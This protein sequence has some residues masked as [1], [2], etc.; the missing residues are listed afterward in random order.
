MSDDIS[1]PGALSEGS[2]RWLAFL[3]T[4]ALIVLMLL[5]AEGAVRIRQ[6][7]KYGSAAG[8]EDYWTIDPKSGMRVP[9]PGLSAGRVSI[10]SLGFRGPEIPAAKPAGTVRVAFLGASTTWCAEVSGNEH[11]WPH[12]VTAALAEAF[13]GS[14][15]DYVNGAVPGYTQ[16]S[17]LKNL[18]LRVA[19]LKPDVIVI[20]EVANNLSGDLREVAAKRGLIADAKMQELNWPSR[21]SK[22]WYL[23]EKNLRVRFAQGAASAGQARLDIDPAELGDDFRRELTRLVRAAQQNARLVALATFSIQL[24]D[25]QSAEQQAKASESAFFYTPFVTPQLLMRSYARYNEIVGEVARE[26]GAMLVEG[27]NEIPGD[28]AHFTDTVHFS[29]AGSRA[30]AQRVSRALIASSALR[31]V[32]DDIAKPRAV[33]SPG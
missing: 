26:T 15:F 22:L 3:V 9:I 23:V 21:Y 33:A 7:L 28:A 25:G 19:P 20:Y 29:D 11:V 14:P 16:S 5:A 10:N 1:R 8:L 2:K 4:A 6:H 18:E 32:V 17:M 30:Q 24:R 27:E 13:P 31:R 12:L